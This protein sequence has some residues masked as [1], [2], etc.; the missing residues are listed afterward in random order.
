MAGTRWQAQDQSGAAWSLCEVR[1]VC[2]CKASG[3]KDGGIRMVW[4]PILSFPVDDLRGSL[5]N[6][7][8]LGCT[9]LRI[10][11]LQISPGK[12]T[13]CQTPAESPVQATTQHVHG[14]GK[15]CRTWLRLCSLGGQLVLFR[16]L[17]SAMN[18]S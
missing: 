15:A 18:F 5:S 10:G 17:N 4:L 16:A 1:K 12:P 11:W 2:G 3:N 13:S 7:R 8:S 6:V 9:P 14:H